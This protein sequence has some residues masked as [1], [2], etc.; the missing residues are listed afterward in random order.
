ME[1]LVMSL[2]VVQRSTCTACKET[3]YEWRYK[4]VAKNYCPRKRQPVI[5]RHI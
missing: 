3:R 1:V 4:G 2:R 5:I